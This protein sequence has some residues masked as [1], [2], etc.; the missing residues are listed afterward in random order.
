MSNGPESEERCQM[1]R[2]G[3]SLT[4]VVI[5][6]LATFELAQN[7]TNNVLGMMLDTLQA[8]T[9]LLQ[10]LHEFAKDEPS[11]SPVTKVLRELISA[12]MD[13]DASIGGIEKKFDR[14]TE[15]I[16][17]TNDANAA[18]SAAPVANGKV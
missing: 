12:V 11:D 13:L 7:K 17:M 8:Q 1:G 16:A 18:G 9:S 14:L 4:D 10:R 2:G 5:A 15:T 3:T 6:K